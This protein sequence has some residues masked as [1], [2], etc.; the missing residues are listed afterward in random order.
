MNYEILLTNF[1]SDIV[2]NISY[3]PL[4]PLGFSDSDFTSD[5]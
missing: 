2:K 3:N 4:L 1:I 5:K